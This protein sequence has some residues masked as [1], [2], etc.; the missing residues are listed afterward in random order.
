MAKRKGSYVYF[1]DGTKVYARD[2]MERRGMLDMYN[3]GLGLA[4]R[5]TKKTGGF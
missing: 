4:G 1:H 3:L 2:D 5:K